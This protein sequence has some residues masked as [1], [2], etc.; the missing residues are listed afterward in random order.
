[1]EPKK[2]RS[3]HRLKKINLKSVDQQSKKVEV[4]TAR[5]AR[6]FLLGRLENLQHIRRHLIGWLTLLIV[7]IGLNAAQIIFNQNYVS[8]A[9]PSENKAYAEGVLG[10]INNLNPLFASTDAEISA[11][12]LMFSSLL[13][14]DTDGKLQSDVAQNYEV[15]PDGRTYTV[16]LK[17]DVQWHDGKQLT[18]KD[19]VYTVQAMQNSL[20]G[21]RQSSSWQNIQVSANGP[22][23]VVF[24]LPTSYA[25]FAS[26]LTF[27]ILPEHILGKVAP[28][29]LQENEFGKHPI[30][31]GPFKF[32]D[33]QTIDVNKEKSALQLT[34]YDN[35]YTGPAKLSRFSLY[36][37][38]TRDELVKGIQYHEVNAASGV[39]VVA[40][41]LKVADVTIN[42]GVFAL[43]RTDNT[44]LK[45]K[46]IRKALTQ[47]LDRQK[48]RAQLGDKKPLEGPIINNQTQTANLVFQQKYDFTVANQ[49]LDQGGWIKG[50]DGVRH[51][52]GQPLELRL[53]A[54][55][56][57]NYKRITKLLNEQWQKLGIKVQIQL[58]DPEQ[59]Q[60]V[61][62]R[63][64]AYDILVYE[65]SQ[66]GDPDGYAFWH[67]SQASS[68]GL[69]FSN[70][71]S[72][73]ADDALLTA[74]GRSNI[75]LRDAKYANF[76]KR[77]VEDVPA[78]ALYRSSL[79]YTTTDGTQSLN[80]TDSLVNAT[81]RYYH[82][83]DWSSEPDATYNTP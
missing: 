83:T 29:E 33:L 68:S 9:Q 46:N 53:V 73:S 63:P 43:Y 4:A 81:D 18:S 66:G 10:P 15:S 74:R 52:D 31:S 35:Y 67:S 26:A 62:L 79:K 41:G 28:E 44:I 64:R 57:V 69:N 32:V 19:V 54:V 48:L 42:N 51:K 23:Q 8:V 78:V 60:Q 13:A 20:T 40:R 58:I 80:S 70:Y 45:D 11:S 16:N 39:G 72:S 55:D 3:W 56:T 47:G 1:M 21:S 30:G 5:H 59:I 61:I 6:K 22:Q 12:K 36:V 2:T 7:L 77:W 50:S 76:A 17:P 65:L 37:Y 24:T 27:P 34:R 82:V 14:Y 25:P 71:V 38:G 75:T 49:L